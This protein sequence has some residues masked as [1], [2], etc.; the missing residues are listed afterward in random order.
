M[1]YLHCPQCRLSV[2]TAADSSSP[3]SCPRCETA[4]NDAPRSMFDLQS[5]KGRDDSYGRHG[6]VRL[7]LVSTGLFRDGTPDSQHRTSDSA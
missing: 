7:A 1:P 5:P 3:Q 4:L 2:H 6:L